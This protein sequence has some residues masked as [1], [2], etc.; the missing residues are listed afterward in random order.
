MGNSKNF[1][2]RISNFG[3]RGTTMDRILIDSFEINS[4]SALRY[5]KFAILLCAVLFAPCSF[6]DAQQTGKVFRIGFLD[7]STASGSAVLVEAFRQELSKLGW[8]EGKN[9]AFEYRF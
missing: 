9:I 8:N 3:L 5:I 4:K 2:L 1:G 6:A 7:G